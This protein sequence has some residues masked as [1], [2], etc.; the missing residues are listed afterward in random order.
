MLLCP[1]ES[2]NCTAQSPICLSPFAVSVVTSSSYQEPLNVLPV[3]D[4]A[5][6]RSRITVRNGTHATRTSQWKRS[7][8]D[9]RIDAKSMVS[10]AICV[11]PIFGKSITVDDLV[12]FIEVN[13]VFGAELFFFYVDDSIDSNVLRCIR[14]YERLGVVESTPWRLPPNLENRIPEKGQYFAMTEC[15]YRLMYRTEYLIIQDIDEL[16]VP[17]RTE[18]WRSMLAQI[19][20]ESRY[21]SGNRIAAYSFRNR[22]FVLTAPSVRPTDIAMPANWSERFRVLTKITGEVDMSPWN[23]QS[24]MMAPP[25]RVL[26][27]HTHEILRHQVVP[28][29]ESIVYVE[30]KDAVQNHYRK[31]RVNTDVQYVNY[32]RMWHFT[33]KVLVRLRKGSEII[34][35]GA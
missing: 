33:S 17:T 3:V 22:Y 9:S 20:A 16:I 6:R 10:F 1:Y 27:W 31:Q 15:G 34:K 2:E 30:E 21:G 32:T 19:N 12:E 7:N 4:L 13:R 11:R 18:D 14:S 26:V 25:E 28:P 5:A 24:K 23:V 29:G 35:L 8:K